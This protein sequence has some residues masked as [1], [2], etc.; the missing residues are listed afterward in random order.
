MLMGE[1]EATGGKVVEDLDIV[2]AATCEEGTSDANRED[3]DKECDE[4]QKNLESEEGKRSQDDDL[5]RV[6]IAL[7]FGPKTR[8]GCTIDA[9]GIMIAVQEADKS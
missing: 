5:N 1:T 9:S 3:A 8:A 6:L 7:E 2:D 4:R